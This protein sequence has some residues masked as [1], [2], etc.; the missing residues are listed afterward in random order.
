[1]VGRSRSTLREKLSRV[2]FG[3]GRAVFQSL[4]GSL[5]D[6]RFHRTVP[7][8][9]GGS[10]VFRIVD[11]GLLTRSRAATFADKEPDTI[12]WIQGFAPGAKLLDI[13]AN[14]GLF[15][16]FAATLGHDVVALEPDAQNF[17]LLQSNLRLNSQ[18]MRGSVRTFPV[19]AHR[20]M[21]IADL[22]ATSDAW[23]SAMNSFDNVVDY[24]GE[25]FEPR[26]SQGAVGM[27]LDDLIRVIDFSPNHLKIDV[28]G[29]EGE[30]IAG[31]R[32]TLASIRL[33]SLLIELDERRGDYAKCITEICANGFRLIE[34]NPS[35]LNSIVGAKSYN[36]IFV[37]D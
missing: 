19:A 18:R 26:F 21:R 22:N 11:F 10:E 35:T 8:V 25:T 14:V 29:N 32:S 2:R 31:A 33:R 30:V 9:L 15:T 36:H 4:P 5:A 12:R 13:G 28:D 27:S 6:G 17:A 7:V 23:G 20:E 16:L 24:K 37:R 3:L 34:K 1:V